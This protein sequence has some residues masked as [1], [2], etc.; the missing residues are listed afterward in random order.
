M[1]QA[2]AGARE[3][4]EERALLWAL[5]VVV[6]I[7]AV[8]PLAR[9]LLEAVA[10]GGTLSAAPLIRV[11]ASPATWTATAHSLVTSVAG[12]VLATVIGTTVGLIVGLTDLR[13][14]NAYVFCFV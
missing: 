7:L 3:R 2:A 5:V 14:R 10:P 9:L 1:I 13:A 4:A 6:A 11:L 8:L 12:T